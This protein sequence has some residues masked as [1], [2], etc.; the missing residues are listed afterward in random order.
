MTKRATVAF[1]AALGATVLT[2]ALAAPANAATLSLGPESCSAGWAVDIAATVGTN[3]PPTQPLVFT[4][5][6]NQGN[7]QSKSF[8]ATSAW[9]TLG[10]TSTYQSDNANHVYADYINWGGLYC[11]R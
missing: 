3:F 11:V 10:F 2:L 9:H 6:V 7:Y 4:A 5:Y 1:G 8:G